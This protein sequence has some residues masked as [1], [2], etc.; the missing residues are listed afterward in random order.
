MYH[1]KHIER[2]IDAVAPFAADCEFNLTKAPLRRYVWVEITHGGFSVLRELE[3]QS[4]F[5]DDFSFHSRH[6]YVTPLIRVLVEA[7]AEVRGKVETP[8]HWM[9][10]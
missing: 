4:H 3:Q 2:A 5:D 6:D 7:I 9:A 10:L 1:S 8:S